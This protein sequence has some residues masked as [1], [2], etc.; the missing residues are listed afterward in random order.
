MSRGASEVCDANL[1]K[2]FLLLTPPARSRE[3]ISIRSRVSVQ[4][5]SG[6]HARRTARIREGG[7]IEAEGRI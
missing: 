2:K 3:K 5:P 4:F 1:E 6:G 7:I